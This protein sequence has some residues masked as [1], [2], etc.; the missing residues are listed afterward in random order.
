MKIRIKGN[1]IRIRLT[2]SEIAQ[3]GAD[4]KLEDCIEFGLEENQRL[5]FILLSEINAEQVFAKFED[6]KIAVIVP[7]T[8]VESWTNSEEVGISGKEILS[9]EKTLRILI[10]KDFTCLVPRT[11]GNDKDAFPHPNAN[12]K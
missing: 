10:E 5:T 11:N 4:G 8:I 7:R 3:F 6:G 1:S 2:Q 9:P 12:E